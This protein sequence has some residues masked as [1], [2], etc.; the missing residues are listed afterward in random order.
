MTGI[1]PRPAK[2][3]DELNLEWDRLAE[4][5]HRQIASGEDLS[6]DH[7]V[8]PTIWSFFEGTDRAVVLDIGSGTGNFTLQLAEVA[9]SVIAIEPSRI[10][11]ALARRVCRTARNVR[12]VEASLEEASHSLDK[13][14]RPPPWPS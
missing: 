10:S 4:E 6:F 11:M 13:N 12:F 2:S 1:R 14:R 8:V 9:R 7:V 3:Y 5:R